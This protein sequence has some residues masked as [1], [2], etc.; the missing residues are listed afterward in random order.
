MNRHDRLQRLEMAVTGPGSDD[1]CPKCGG[2]QLET[3]MRQAEALGDDDAPPDAAT[4]WQDMAASRCRRCVGPT[5][6]ALLAQ[7]FST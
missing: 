2:L 6:L 3:L 1:L 4:D 7:E 5:L